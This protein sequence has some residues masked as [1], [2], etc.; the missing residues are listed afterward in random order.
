[1]QDVSHMLSVFRRERRDGLFRSP[2]FRRTG[3]RS[4]SFSF[5][6]DENGGTVFF[7]LLREN[8]GTVFLGE[9]GDGLFRSPP[10]ERGAQA[11]VRPALDP[12]FFVLPHPEVSHALFRIFHFQGSFF[13]IRMKTVQ[14]VK[15]GAQPTARPAPDP[16]FFHSPPV[17]RSG[18]SFLWG[19]F[20][21]ILR[22]WDY[23]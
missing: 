21:I 11:T 10:R 8:G 4:F 6:E 18:S 5:G 20:F 2:L 23:L 14:S 22:R 7:V 3:G 15:Q 9:R 12:V 16:V 19:S 1:M 17:S 13:M